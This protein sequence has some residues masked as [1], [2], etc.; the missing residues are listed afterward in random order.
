MG[1]KSKKKVSGQRRGG[2]VNGM[3][4]VRY[5]DKKR[6]VEFIKKGN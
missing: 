3:G 4:G 5:S 1:K 6:F 2:R